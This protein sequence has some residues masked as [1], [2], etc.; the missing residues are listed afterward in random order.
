MNGGIKSIDV[1][2]G[3]NGMFTSAEANKAGASK[4]RKALVYPL[5]TRFSRQILHTA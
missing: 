5:V 2:S 4:A 3:D 1:F